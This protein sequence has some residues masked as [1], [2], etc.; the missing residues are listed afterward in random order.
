MPVRH[1]LKFLVMVCFK[2]IGLR[3]DT[4]TNPSSVNFLVATEPGSL[5][6]LVTRVSPFSKVVMY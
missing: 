4:M 2:I 5:T 3:F 6:S 1:A